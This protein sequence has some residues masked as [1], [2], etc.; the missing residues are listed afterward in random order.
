VNGSTVLPP[1][2]TASTDRSQQKPGMI[3]A[4][5]SAVDAFAAAGWEW[6]GYWTSPR[7]YQHFSATNR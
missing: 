1:A 7:D 6:G 2:G 5:D 3:H 4:G